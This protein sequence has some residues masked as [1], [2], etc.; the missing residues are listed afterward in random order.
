MT[1]SDSLQP[2]IEAL[3]G[4][5]IA[6]IAPVSGGDI[7]RAFC[8]TGESRRRW[9]LKTN[10]DAAAALMFRREAQGLALLGASGVIRTPRVYGHG[11][12]ETGNAFLLLSFVDS[13]PR[14]PLFWERFGRQLA[15]LHSQTSAF[16]GFAHDN[17]IG[18][19]P[20]SN[21]RCETWAE[22]YAQERL[23]PQMQLAR[24]QGYLDKAAEQQL[25][26]LC[27]RLDVRC[28]NEPPALTHGD[29]WSGNFLCNAQG[30]PVLID[31]AAAYAHREMDIAMSRLFGGFDARFYAAYQEAWP[32]A[33]G[34]EERIEIYQLYYLL[35]HVNLFG[36]GYESGVRRILKAQS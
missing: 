9:F 32:L 6:S 3:L 4:E 26:R 31:P 1:L 10:T 20:Q 15:A 18:R 19:L 2:R 30:E 22:F 8:L 16:F 25:E 23:Q 13:G 29:L 17:F 11:A 5:K 35:V 14:S 12:D 7:N 33:P 28:P 36:S 34:F 24:Q 21:R 27:R